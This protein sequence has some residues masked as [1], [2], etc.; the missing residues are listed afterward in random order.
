MYKNC[1]IANITSRN[2]K[3]LEARLGHLPP[4]LKSVT[5]IIP[6]SLVT[7]LKQLPQTANLLP[8]IKKIKTKT[9]ILQTCPIYHPQIFR[10]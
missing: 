6:K 1:R 3:D 4:V 8:E 5:G 7:N 9:V 2:I 10:T